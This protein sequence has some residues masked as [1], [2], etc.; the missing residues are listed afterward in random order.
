MKD[1]D[2]KTKKAESK[3]ITDKEGEGVFQVA[4]FSKR[5]NTEE[6]AVSQLLRFQK[7]KKSESEIRPKETT[8]NKS[9]SQLKAAAELREAV[10]KLN[11][12]SLFQN[13]ASRKKAEGVTD[14]K[15]N[16]FNIKPA[17]RIDKISGR[18][19]K[20]KEDKR[21]RSLSRNEGEHADLTAASRQKRGEPKN[22]PPHWQSTSELTRKSADYMAAEMSAA[23]I[24][25]S[26]DKINLEHYHRRIEDK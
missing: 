19:I 5:L 22:P 17:Y 23:T 20:I 12:L 9:A 7:T 15:V 24:Q 13:M 21:H 8:G 14:E 1:P 16:R 6:G 18:L 11:A 4:K 26:L 10:K 25:K 2:G 3:V